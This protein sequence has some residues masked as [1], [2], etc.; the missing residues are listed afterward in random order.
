MAALS[1]REHLP[2][3]IILAS[4]S[5]D[6]GDDTLM[7]PC[8]RQQLHEFDGINVTGGDVGGVRA[9]IN[10]EDEPGN[11]SA[12]AN[13]VTISNTSTIYTE[14]ESIAIVGGSMDD[15]EH[16]EYEHLLVCRLGDGDGWLRRRSEM[17][18]TDSQ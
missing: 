9:A 10:A 15:D 2:R 1:N 3:T 8:R 6:D 12:T 17:W 16:Y 4:H 5:D 13:T 7:P 11:A 14:S 18:E